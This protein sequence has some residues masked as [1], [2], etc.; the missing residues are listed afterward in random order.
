MNVVH[1]LKGGSGHGGTGTS[2]KYSCTEFAEII[3]REKM[4]YGNKTPY[5]R[6]IGEIISDG[7]AH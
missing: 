1:L 4:E 2:G 3:S 7:R 6:N 5:T